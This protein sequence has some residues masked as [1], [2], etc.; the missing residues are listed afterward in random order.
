MERNQHQPKKPD[1]L[2]KNWPRPTAED[3]A[4]NPQRIVIVGDEQD[5]L[6]KDN[7]IKTSKYEIY[8]FLPKFLFEEFNPNTKIANCYF[9]F[10]AALQ[11]VPQISNTGGY[12]TTLI[13]LVGVL[14][15]AA[16]LKIMEDIER[17]KADNKAN[18]SIAEVFDP[19]TNEFVQKL[20]WQIE[21]GSYV[22]IKSRESIPADLIVV[23]VW[24]P[25]PEL[26]KGACYVE[27][28]S[29]DGETNLKFRSCPAPLVGQVFF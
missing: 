5:Y 15:I 26:P 27:T 7:S 21:V 16:V 9:L 10:I 24:E 22:R 28:K 25:N 14:I 6:F 4:E 1:S 11:C 18:S 12:P 17:H 8:D 29:L 2:P 19:S 23:Q 13:P 3:L 20:W